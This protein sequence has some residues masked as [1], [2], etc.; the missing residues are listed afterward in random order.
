MGVSPVRK[1]NLFGLSGIF[2]PV[3]GGDM[4]HFLSWFHCKKGSFGQV[5]L[6]SF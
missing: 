3:I 2:E 5:P 1:V 4:Y 6:P